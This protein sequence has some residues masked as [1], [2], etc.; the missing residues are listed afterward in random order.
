M[1]QVGA[2]CRGFDAHPPAYT[3]ILCTTDAQRAIVMKSRLHNELQAADLYGGWL[4]STPEFEVKAMMAHSANE[5]M[6]HAEQLASAM[7]PSTTGRCQRRLRCSA[8]SPDYTAR[9]RASQDSL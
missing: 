3:Y 8:R 6:E 1:E 9:A 5:E 2:F 7:T 4:R